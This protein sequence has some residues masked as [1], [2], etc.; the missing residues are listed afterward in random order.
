MPMCSPL[1]LVRLP[2]ASRPQ[3]GFGLVHGLAVVVDGKLAP[4]CAGSD[5]MPSDRARCALFWSFMFRTVTSHDEQL[6]R[7]TELLGFIA[8]RVPR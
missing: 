5:R 1:S 8:Y 6:M 7:Y 2:N 4:C 3:L